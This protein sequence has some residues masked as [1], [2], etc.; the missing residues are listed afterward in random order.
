MYNGV[1]LYMLKEG[2]LLNSV[3][4]NIGGGHQSYGDLDNI[5]GTR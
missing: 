4:L 2:D 3:L 1:Y 5:L